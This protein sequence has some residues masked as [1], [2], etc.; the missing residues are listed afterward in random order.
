MNTSCR[1]PTAYCLLPNAPQMLMRA[2]EQ[3]LVRHGDRGVGVLVPLA[4]A[5]VLVLAAA[6]RVGRQLLELRPGREHMRRPLPI[7]DVEPLAGMHQAPPGAADTLL[8]D[9]LAGLPLQADEGAILVDEVEVLANDDARTNALR[10]ARVPPEAM[11]LGDVPRAA[12]L[13][14][15]TRPAEARQGDH[16]LLVADRRRVDQPVRTLVL[17]QSQARPQLGPLLRVVGAHHA[18]PAHNEFVVVADPDHDRSAPRADPRLALHA[19]L[20]A[21]FRDLPN[22]LAALLVEGV[23]GGVLAGADDK[24]HHVLPDH[25]RAG[26]PPDVLLLAEVGALPE[27][28]AVEIIAEQ[29]GGA[30]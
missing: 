10:G 5:L 12:R 24:Q 17:R 9:L 22:V 13:D 6:E 21:R 16:H 3:L 25:R 19:R 30:V 18:G 14:R 28:L 23:Q 7:R 27:F 8:E 29:A 2:D 20:A 26:V 1:L 4:L 11:R 15:Q